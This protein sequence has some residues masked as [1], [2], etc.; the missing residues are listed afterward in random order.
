MTDPLNIFVLEAIKNDKNIPQVE[1]ALKKA[2]KGDIKKEYDFRGQLSQ[3]L[4]M[5]EAMYD[6]D[7]KEFFDIMKNHSKI[8]KNSK[9]EAE[10]KI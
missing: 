5:Q 4:A 9:I 1:Y 3:S 6:A 10:K 2:K 8:V 7:A